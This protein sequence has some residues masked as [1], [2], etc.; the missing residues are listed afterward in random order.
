M[1]NMVFTFDHLRDWKNGISYT[2]RNK[3]S[4]NDAEKNFSVFLT[5]MMIHN[6]DF[7]TFVPTFI[8]RLNADIDFGFEAERS[9]KI[10]STETAERIA[11]DTETPQIFSERQKDIEARPKLTPKG[12][13]NR[14]GGLERKVSQRLSRKKKATMFEDQARAPGTETSPGL[15]RRIDEGGG[16]RYRGGRPQVKEKGRRTLI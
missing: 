5:N 2:Q 10:K 11:G 4:G 13:L 3:N 15:R 7:R 16:W 1:L 14:L 6:K 12:L 9:R 8:A